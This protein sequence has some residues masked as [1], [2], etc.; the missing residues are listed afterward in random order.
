MATGINNRGDIVGWSI[1]GG[2]GYPHAVLWS[3]GIMIDLGTLGGTT[4]QANG[5]NNR[6]DIV[7]WS[8]TANNVSYEATVWTPV[9]G[10]V[11]EPSTWALMLLGFA[12]LGV[13]FQQSR[14]GAVTHHGFGREN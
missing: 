11:P 10:A 6:G 9:R 1:Y 4:S 5:I 12:G 3:D 8:Y 14:C 13:A 2:T 7:G